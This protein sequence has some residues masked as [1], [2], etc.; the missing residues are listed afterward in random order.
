PYSR[1]AQSN[2]PEAAPYPGTDGPLRVTTPNGSSSVLGE[3]FIAAGQ[4]AGYPYTPD[5]NGAQQEGFGPY[6]RTTHDGKRWSTARGYLDPVRGRPNLTIVTGALALEILF[7]GD[8]AVGIA[9][10][11]SGQRNKARA[12]RE[13]I[14][15][16]GA[17]NS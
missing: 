2:R 8:R 17:I 9:Y 1:R 7:E 10:S 6:D 12:E 11:S 14:L 13:V 15:S 16:G 5:C 3:A 4:Q